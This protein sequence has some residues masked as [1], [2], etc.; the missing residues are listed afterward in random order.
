[1][2]YSNLKVYNDKG[3]RVAVFGAPIGAVGEFDASG[4]TPT[5]WNAIE[6]FEVTCSK[7]DQF[8]KK[9][10]KELWDKYNTE[11]DKFDG[12][13][14]N[15][16]YHPK[17]HTIAPED[18]KRPKW[19]FLKYV[20]D[21]FHKERLVVVSPAEGLNVKNVKTFINQKTKEVYIKILAKWPSKEA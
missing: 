19:S 10:A 3:Q 2:Y 17:I 5:H 14:N 11:K 9:L 12:K 4:A 15:C 16:V 8:S 21:T 7:K 6:V 13:C 20:N 1:M 18:P